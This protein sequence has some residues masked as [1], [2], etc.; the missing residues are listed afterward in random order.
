[1]LLRHYVF[2][3]G[4]RYHAER[5]NSCRHCFFWK[6]KAAGCILGPENCYYLADLTPHET[7]RCSGCRYA[8]NQTCV[9]AFCY[10]DYDKELEKKGR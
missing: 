9:S 3:N 5:P 1:M 8:K 2:K 4:V 10:R 6:N 7:S